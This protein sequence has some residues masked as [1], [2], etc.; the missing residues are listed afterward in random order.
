MTFL[1]A[2][3]QPLLFTVGPIAVHT[4]GVLAAVG[5]LAG[6]SLTLW[7]MRQYARVH[8]LDYRVHLDRIFFLTIFSG[9]LGARLLFVLYNLDYFA[10][11]P[12]G[13][14]RIW[15][16]G[17]VWHGGLACVFLVLTLYCRLMGINLLQMADMLAPGAALGHAIGR[18]GNYVNQEAYGAPTNLPWGIP[19]DQLHRIAGY[20]ANI[21]FQPTFLYES[22]GNLT[23]FFVLL[24]L[25]KRRACMFPG[26]LACTYLALYSIVRFFVE[27]IRIDP[28][29]VLFGLR[30]PQWWSMGI[31][32]IALV[33]LIFLKR[34]SI[35]AQGK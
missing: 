33:S 30:A 27:F 18:W 25:F 19:I 22:L 10:L 28:V 11:D 1:P 7:V 14:A 15:E 5:A 20:E 16:G 8:A 17:M 2:P 34:R 31:F 4:Y 6:Y 3:P 26:I 23:I 35:L 32:G 29:P 21:Y 13:I 12:A 24:V 9:L